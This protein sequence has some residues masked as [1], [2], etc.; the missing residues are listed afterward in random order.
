MGKFA[1]IKKITEK[2]EEEP[3]EM[4]SDE[5]T[6]TSSDEESSGDEAVENGTEKKKRAELWVNRERVLILCSRGTDVRTRH[7]LKDLKELLPHAKGDSKLDRQKSLTA[8]NEIAEMKN[9]TKVMYFESKK[10]KDTFLWLAN[11]EKGPSAKFLVHN[12]HTLRE[13]KLSGNCLKASRPILAFDDAF[14]A[15]PHLALIKTMLI[16]TLGTPNHHPRSQPF[17]DH[18]FNFSVGEGDK[19]WFRNFQIVDESLQLQEIGPRFVLETVR[20]FADSFQGAV[21]YDNPNYVSPNVIRRQ[22]RNG[23]TGY[24]ERQLHHK[25]MDIKRQTV[26][27]ILTEKVSDPVGKEF[28]T[29]DVEMSEAAQAITSKIDKPKRKKKK[30]AKR[31]EKYTHSVMSGEYKQNWPPESEG[32]DAYVRLNV[33]G[34]LYQ[35]TL[36]T[37]K[38]QDT[39]LRAMF[40]GRLEV[41][42]DENGWVLIDR[43]GKHF[44]VL[45]DYLRD[46]WVPLP[47]CK[48]EIQQILNE[49]RYFLIQ[50]LQ[51]E[52]ESWLDLHSQKTSRAKTG[53]C[54]ILTVTSKEE[55]EEIIIPSLK[56][57]IVLLLNR[58]NNKFSYT[59]QSDD[60]LL[61]NLELFERLAL[62]FH[63]RILFIKDMGTHSS[64]IC[65]WRFY[66]QSALRAG[67]CCTSIVYATDR[68]QT[69]VEFPDSK[70]LRRG[71]VDPS[72]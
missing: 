44:G 65:Q 16:Q 13:L 1:K 64:E 39:M 22:I 56:P 8:L 62:K 33:G 34:A 28:N 46:G 36:A 55:A 40:S 20:V 42:K 32:Q 63:D 57:S 70:N 25:A 60:N 9:C 68:K 27:Q 58:H 18:V 23:K 15:K 49:A 3:E 2:K 21:L 11:V 61:K 26:N 10:K 53:T 12:I 6:D 38:K 4:R 71:H 43:N 54:S 72:L 24:I 50:G 52:C 47:D 5:G 51:S 41:L 37:L 31:S 66:G 14:D 45:L 35:T 48:L 7:L 59:M 30:L 67:V 17:V 69:K 29:K 19:I